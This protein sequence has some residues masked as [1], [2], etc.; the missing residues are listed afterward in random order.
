MLFIIEWETF[1][2]ESTNEKKLFIFKPEPFK[3]IYRT[4][5]SGEN[6]EMQHFH[7]ISFKFITAFTF[8]L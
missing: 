5:F 1:V 7:L 8:D 3:M 6:I 2:F 4:S